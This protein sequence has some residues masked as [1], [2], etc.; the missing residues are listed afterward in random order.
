MPAKKR[1]ANKPVAVGAPPAVD[2]K[3]RKAAVEAP[4][5]VDAKGQ[6]PPVTDTK[7][8]APV[9]DG[10][11]DEAYCMA[12]MVAKAVE[13]WDGLAPLRQAVYTIKYTRLLQTQ[14]FESWLAGMLPTAIEASR[15]KC[16]VLAIIRIS[17]MPDLSDIRRM[18][19]IDSLFTDMVMKEIESIASGR[20]DT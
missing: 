18:H 16:P 10:N 20:S 9:P 3:K 6:V 17:R 14:S 2:A 15:T 12:K 13:L 4:P 8:Q 7:G 1:K 11:H 19:A 5:T